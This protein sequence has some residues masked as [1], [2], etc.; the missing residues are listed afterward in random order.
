M[1]VN[2]TLNEGLKR[3]LDVVIPAQELDERL[4]K[5]LDEL[6]DRVRIPGFRPGKVPLAHL[7]RVY[8]RDAMKEIVNETVTETVRTSIDGRDEKPALQPDVDITE[9]ALETV[10]KGGVDLTF[11]ISYEVLPEFEL[12]DFKS[13]KI[14][15]LIAEVEDGDID[16]R[17][18]QIADTNKPY[19]AKGEG[20]EA[21]DGDRLTMSYV[22]KIDGEAFEG[23]TDDNGQLVIGSGRFIPG[24][25]E[26]LIGAKAGD[27][28]TVTVTFPE[29]YPAE[30]LAGKEAVFDV[31]V[32]DIEAPE[33]L[34]I[35]DEFASRFGI[36]SLDK[37]KEAIRE[38]I[39]SEF[40][41]ETR[42][43]IKR[44]LLDHLDEMH[45]FDL[46]PTLLESE[47]E[48]IW[49]Q[50]N[51]N[52]EQSGRTFEDEDTTE[53]KAREEY[54]GIAE[55][56]VRL[57]LVLS[58]IGEKNSIQVTDE[59]LQR[60]LY[61]K[62]SQFPGQEK[63]VFEFYENNPTAL[64]SLRAPIYEEKVIDF[65]IELADVTDKTVSKDELFA[66]SEDAE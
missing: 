9:D 28:K 65:I 7:K 39:V 31:S 37:F 16:E 13:I 52:M 26:Q 32:K 45:K 15:R 56:R 18:S 22:G 53:E 62:V 43:K 44:Q 27:D 14:E 46:P 63:Q 5:Y 3:E 64:A 51:Q 41:N 6:K 30:H 48:Q 2:E 40:G 1:Q 36:E 66:E 12:G 23:G 17:L 59:E 29:D 11:K 49:N 42:Q 21:A 38:Q 34:K 61:E 60:A 25:E 10:I 24:F 54:R 4:V 33:E 50:L 55:R 58:E 19:T 8:G 57:G 20:A 47:F 35:D